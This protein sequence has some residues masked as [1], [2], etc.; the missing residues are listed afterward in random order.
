MLTLLIVLYSVFCLQ[1]VFLMKGNADDD[2]WKQRVSEKKGVSATTLSFS[3]RLV[4]LWGRGWAVS[5]FYSRS[6][7]SQKPCPPAVPILCLQRAK[8]LSPALFSA[9]DLGRNPGSGGHFWPK[10]YL[11]RPFSDKIL[12]PAADLADAV[13]PKLPRAAIYRSSTGAVDTHPG[14]T[15]SS[16]P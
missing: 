11:W 4:K 13:P 5:E 8:P 3:L 1:L 12:L 9:D 15:R 10:P 2:N 6:R 16:S 14:P 7:T